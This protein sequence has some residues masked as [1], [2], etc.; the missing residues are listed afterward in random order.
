MVS[1]S[2]RPFGWTI[3]APSPLDRS[4]AAFILR[5]TRY[6]VVLLLLGALLS[7]LPSRATADLYAFVPGLNPYSVMEDPMPSYF[8]GTNCFAHATVHSDDYWDRIATV[9]L[10]LNGERVFRESDPNGIDCGGEM[11]GY[12]TIFDPGVWF[13][14]THFVDAGYVTVRVE[15]WSQNGFHVSATGRSVVYNKA[16]LY[17]RNEWCANPAWVSS[18]IQETEDHLVNMR[19]TIVHK[20]TTK[21]WTAAQ[22]INDLKD[23]TALHIMTH[24]ADSLTWTNPPYATNHTANFPVLLSDRDEAV[25]FNDTEY[26]LARNEDATTPSWP[27]WHFQHNPPDNQQWCRDAREEAYGSEPNWPFAPPF[28][29]GR[30]N[31]GNP[32]INVALINACDISSNTSMPNLPNYFATAILWAPYDYTD[33]SLVA[34]KLTIWTQHEKTRCIQFWGGLDSG[35]TTSLARDNMVTAVYGAGVLP[36]DYA[37]CWGDY[38]TTL[39]RAYTGSNTAAANWWYRP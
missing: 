12:A 28:Y 39:H 21:G 5:S 37:A 24:G 11:F 16:T 31:L 8:S 34:W 17:G 9:E 7:A 35:L 22:F 32:P 3:P 23:C 2:A 29:C 36:T 30:Y 6:C 13:D 1:S 38:Y 20:N 14:S 33:R 19:H 18:G 25:G 27:G 10:Y 4:A 15:A 26:I